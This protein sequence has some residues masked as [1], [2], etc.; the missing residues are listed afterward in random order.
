M[1]GVAN[2]EISAQIK[3]FDEKLTYWKD[4]VFEEMKLGVAMQNKSM[5]DMFSQMQLEISE[6]HHSHIE[7]MAKLKQVRGDGLVLTKNHPF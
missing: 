3:K 1:Q 5:S 7:E 6:H 4:Q 2:E